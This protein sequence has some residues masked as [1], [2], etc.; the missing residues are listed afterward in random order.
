MNTDLT[1][2][3]LVKVQVQSGTNSLTLPDNSKLARNCT[4][5]AVV[6]LALMPTANIQMS[7]PFWSFNETCVQTRY[8]R[9]EGS[10]DYEVYSSWYMPRWEDAQIPRLRTVGHI[11][12]TYK[13]QG[14]LKWLPYEDF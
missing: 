9:E 12:A 11:Q 1:T 2:T 7:N 8:R 10:G 6:V 4:W 13:F 14:R 5:P 3:S